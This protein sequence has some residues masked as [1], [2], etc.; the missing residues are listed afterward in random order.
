MLTKEEV[1]EEYKYMKTIECTYTRRAGFGKNIYGFIYSKVDRLQQN[2]GQY[3]LRYQPPVDRRVKILSDGIFYVPDVKI[4][5]TD[6]S[7]EYPNRETLKGYVIS[8][9]AFINDPDVELEILGKAKIEV[10]AEIHE[11]VTEE[12][13][14]EPA[15]PKRRNYNQKKK[16]TPAQQKASKSNLAKARAAKAARKKAEKKDLVLETN[17]T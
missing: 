13:S 6:G 7:Y 2:N 1:L 8:G 14:Q 5:K 10:A 3:I 11:M 4:K 12:I 17:E 15:D 9:R 16:H